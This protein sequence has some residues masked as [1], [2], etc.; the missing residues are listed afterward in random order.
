VI[1][2]G[3]SFFLQVTTILTRGAII[4]NG[5]KTLSEVEITIYF[6]DKNGKEDLEEKIT[7]LSGN[8]SASGKIILISAKNYL[9]NLKA[10]SRL[11]IKG[12][13]IVPIAENL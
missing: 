5:N 1:L 9:N 2:T 7:S 6:L 13:R 8:S 4:N 10:M 11:F 3:V 12:C